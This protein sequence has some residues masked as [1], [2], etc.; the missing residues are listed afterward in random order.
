LIQDKSPEYELGLTPQIP[1]EPEWCIL[2][3]KAMKE[4]I[5]S[6]NGKVVDCQIQFGFKIR[7]NGQN[8]SPIFLFRLLQIAHHN[9]NEQYKDR[10]KGH[11]AHFLL[12]EKPEFKDYENILR[13]VILGQGTSKQ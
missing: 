12:M 3:I 5:S 8:L 1:E 7:E 11:R 13:I 9:L 6:V 4:A 10:T 2:M